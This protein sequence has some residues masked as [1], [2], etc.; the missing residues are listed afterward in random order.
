MHASTARRFDR[1]NNKRKRRMK[2]VL[3]TLIPNVHSEM[4]P[5]I[6]IDVALSRHHRKGIPHL[7]ASG[8]DIFQFN[9]LFVAK[10]RAVVNVKIVAGH[11]WV[12]KHSR[13]TN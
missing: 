4:E 2:Q 12:S 1:L 13:A 11:H 9:T 3:A 10:G 7:L 6:T 5:N 8:I